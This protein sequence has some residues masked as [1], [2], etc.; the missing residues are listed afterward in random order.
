MRLSHRTVTRITF[1]VLALLTF[2]F[3]S[4]LVPAL[5]APDP[6]IVHLLTGGPQ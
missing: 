5:L 1:F 6:Q 4:C 2:L 3:W